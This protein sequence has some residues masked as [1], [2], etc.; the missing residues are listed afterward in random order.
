MVM[1]YLV[2]FLQKGKWTQMVRSTTVEEFIE[3]EELMYTTYS[4]IPGLEKYYKE[5]WLDSKRSDLVESAHAALKRLLRTSVGGFDTVFETIHQLVTL[6]IGKIDEALETS[7]SKQ[8]HVSLAM[9]VYRRLSFNVT[10]HAITTIDRQ[11]KKANCNGCAIKITHGLPFTC[12]ISRL[13]NTDGY[14]ELDSIHPFWKTLHIRNISKGDNNDTLLQEKNKLSKL[15]DVV[16]NRDIEMMRKVSEFV[17]NVSLDPRPQLLMF[18]KNIPDLNIPQPMN[19]PQVTRPT[20]AA[21]NVSKDIPDLN[22]PHYMSSPQWIIDWVNVDGD[23]NCGY[24]AVAQ[25]IYGDEHRW[26]TVRRDMVDELE[27][28]THIYI[29]LYGGEM[30]IDKLIKR[31]SWWKRDEDT[32]VIHWMDA[33]MGFIIAN[34]YDEIFTCLS[35]TNSFTSLPMTR[36][37]AISQGPK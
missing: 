36:T 33:D 23:G 19:C 30:E 5:T 26:P 17:E 7:L 10:H 16:L 29:R 34:C 6:Q 9:S 18:Q 2:K 8:L 11:F 13:L 27:K 21:T 12:D 22:I 14:I 24:R 31:I 20:A 37:S 32:P 28:H 1:L 4:Y 3:N 15:V 35:H 25:E